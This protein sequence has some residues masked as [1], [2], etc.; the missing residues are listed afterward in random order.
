MR[1]P[2]VVLISEFESQRA[3]NA[4]API[5]R[6]QRKK[7]KTQQDQFSM[8]GAAPVSLP[9]PPPPPPSMAGNFDPLAPAFPPIVPTTGGQF[10]G[11]SDDEDDSTDPLPP[12][13][14]VAAPAPAPAPVN[15]E[16]II[17]GLSSDS[18]IEEAV[19][20]SDS[21]NIVMCL[22]EEVKH[23]KSWRLTLKSGII[24]PDIH[25]TLSPKP[26]SPK[27]HFPYT[28]D[29]VFQRGSADLVFYNP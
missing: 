27:I 10:D 11:N 23:T 7:Q 17:G 5:K 18:E 12:P 3:N 24:C 14:P 9:L 8:I 6:N 19:A 25:N 28:R 13:A 26:L 2:P 16:D 29:I 15:E 1:Q 4:L 22:Y 20:V 21:P